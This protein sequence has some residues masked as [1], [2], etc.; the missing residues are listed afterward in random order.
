[1]KFKIENDY[2]WIN[3]IGLLL[4]ILI[5]LIPI[6]PIRVFL[7]ILFIFLLPGYVFISALFPK[8]DDLSIFERFALS[9][10]FSIAIIA[11]TG[12][13][14]NFTPFGIRIYSVIISISIFIIICSIITW[15]RRN[16]LPEKEKFTLS[17]E[18]DID[19]WKEKESLDKSISLA[20]II[21]ITLVIGMLIYMM[22]KPKIGERFTEFYILGPDEMAHN[23]PRK[24]VIGE[25][26]EVIVGIIN[27]EHEDTKY[28]LIINIS[29]EEI[30][31]F[32]SISLAHD[33]KWEKKIKIVPEKIGEKIKV[34]FLL[35]KGKNKE[36]YRET[37]LW[38]DV[39][40]R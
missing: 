39:Y 8:K 26:S 29:G 15:Y 40:E 5:Y 12:F 27:R 30:N 11:L 18:F 14:L 6:Q 17:F 3:L 34:E 13:I 20:L 19:K 10:G 36:P 21:S 25:E 24:L 22:A 7:G 33:E 16:T 37:H 2:L 32:S 38:I 4:I 9:F 23:Y 1:L 31:R 28:D 35:F